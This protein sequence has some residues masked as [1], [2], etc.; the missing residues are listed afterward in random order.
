MIGGSSR[1]AWISSDG[2]WRRVEGKTSAAARSDAAEISLGYG[3]SV[4]MRDE[5]SWSD[6]RQRHD[7]WQLE[8]VEVRIGHDSYGNR[9]VPGARRSDGMR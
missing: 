2:A 5:V 9:I 7:E 1:E 3:A 8:E 6:A 4:P